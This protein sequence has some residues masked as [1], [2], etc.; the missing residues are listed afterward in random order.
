MSSDFEFS[1]SCWDSPSTRSDISSSSPLTKHLLIWILSPS[2]IKA[3]RQ[4]R[5]GKGRIQWDSLHCECVKES[6][7]RLS[8][9][10]SERDTS[11]ISNICSSINANRKEWKNERGDVK[12]LWEIWEISVHLISSHIHLISLTWHEKSFL[13]IAMQNIKKWRHRLREF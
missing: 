7:N 13:R 8:C 6:Y 10:L 11:F 1:I 5:I 12:K 3:Y 9:P 4:E 2:P